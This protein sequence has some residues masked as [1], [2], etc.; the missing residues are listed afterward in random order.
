[1][2]DTTVS[3][4]DIRDFVQGVDLLFKLEACAICSQDI[5]PHVDSKATSK[6]GHSYHSECLELWEFAC[7][8]KK[9]SFSCPNCHETIVT[10]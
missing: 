8:A 6:C 2:A 7:A 4:A 5:V 3:M 10:R 9:E 1:M